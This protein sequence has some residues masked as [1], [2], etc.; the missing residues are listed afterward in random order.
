MSVSAR[1][2]LGASLFSFALLGGAAFASSHSERPPRGA[3]GG[4]TEAPTTASAFSVRRPDFAIRP[5]ATITVTAPQ[6]PASA[7][8]AAVRR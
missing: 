6:A 2:L 4:R 3:N 7:Q 8:P 5:A 1:T